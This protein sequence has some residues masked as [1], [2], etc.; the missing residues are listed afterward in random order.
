VSELRELANQL[1]KELFQGRMALYSGQLK[2]PSQIRVRRRA[3]ARIETL[4]GERSN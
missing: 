2:N 1:R 3:I 4:L